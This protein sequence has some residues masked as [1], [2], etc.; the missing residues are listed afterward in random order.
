MIRRRIAAVALAAGLVA[1]GLA[2]NPAPPHATADDSTLAGEGGTFASP[3]V[4]QLE[5]DATAPGASTVPTYSEL[6][7]VD[8]ARDDFVAGTAD[9]AVSEYPLTSQQAATAERNGRSFA[10]IPFAAQAVTLGF[11]LLRTQDTTFQPGTLYPTVQLTVPTLADIFTLNGISQWLDPQITAENGGQQISTSGE[12]NISLIFSAESSAATSSLIQLF[13]DDTTARV[14]WDHYATLEKKLPDTAYESW[15]ADNG[16]QG[17]DRGLAETF[18]PLDTVTGLPNSNPQYMGQGD[19][20]PIPMDWV[21]SP[22]NIPTVSIQNAAG[23]YVAPTPTS[24]SAALADASM[25]PTSKL[26]AFTP[27]P[28]DPL[29]YSLPAMSY[30]IVPTTGLDAAKA[31]ALAGLIRFALSDRGQADVAKLGGVALPA[32][33]RSAGLAVAGVVADEASPPPTTT[34]PPTAA[35]ATTG[36]VTPTTVAP[37]APPPPTAAANA[38]A[39]V[40][41]GTLP[42][43]P[44]RPLVRSPTEVAKAVASTTTTSEPPVTAGAAAPDLVLPE[45]AGSGPSRLA[46]SV[47]AVDY[48]KATQPATPTGLIVAGGVVLAAGLGGRRLAR[49]RTR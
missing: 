3:I 22:W 40:Q 1:A 25:D 46:T 17:A 13:L 47:G 26:V 30:L 2:A 12:T 6:A 45:P 24:M 18:H 9:F 43:P 5:L 42:P 39:R 44:S 49:R 48:A 8:A 16:V 15:V 28:H 41:G 19:I 37:T 33:I 38:A 20:G 35:P 21:V 27:T 29:A 23:A 11:V 34:T 36:T 4:D 14:T 32:S 31:T 10:Y 7:G